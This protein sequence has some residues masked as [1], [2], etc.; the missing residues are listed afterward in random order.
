MIKDTPLKTTKSDRQVLGKLH[1]T[2]LRCSY[3][4][5]F[6]AALL[7]EWRKSGGRENPH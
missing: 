1:A 2:S 4:L 6:H 5:I 7:L 3:K